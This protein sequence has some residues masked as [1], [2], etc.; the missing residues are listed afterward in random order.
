MPRARK[1]DLGVS[2]RVLNRISLLTVINNIVELDSGLL[3]GGVICILDISDGGSGSC[4]GSGRR[5]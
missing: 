2:S 5:R 3:N 1:G 4:G